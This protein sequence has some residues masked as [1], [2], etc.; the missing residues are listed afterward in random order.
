MVEM[1]VGSMGWIKLADNR[2]YLQA[3][4][5]DKELHRKLGNSSLLRR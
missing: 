5:D 2:K 1:Q 3:G 4:E